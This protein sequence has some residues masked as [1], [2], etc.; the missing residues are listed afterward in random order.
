MRTIFTL[1]RGSWLSASSYR[2]QMVFSVLNLA[3]VVLPLF[4]ITRAL[5]GVMADKIA[6]EGGNYFAFVLLGSVAIS[7]ASE[8][9]GAFP[10]QLSGVVGSGMLDSFLSSPTHPI[11]LFVGLSGYQFLWLLL[12]TVLYVG[13]GVML[14]AN[15]SLSQIPAGMVVIVFI[16]LAHLP[17]AL[18]SAAMV[19]AFRT[20]SPL[21]AA[22]LLVSNLLGGVYF[23][24]TVVP[25]WI[26]SLTNFVPL[27]Y[28]SRALRKVL[29]D[30]AGL[31]DV[32]RDLGAMLLI[33]VVLGALGAWALKLAFSYARR[34]GTLSQY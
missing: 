19:V 24:T 29:L 10:G 9:M 12:R 3:A 1:I 34:A 15:V 7:F 26:G 18:I 20:P 25:S 13:V 32:A 23:P 17:F 8:T 2:L 11:T 6:L 27:S 4:F 30:G 21:N 33:G 22:V 31:A 28:G 14:G 5:Q 16:M